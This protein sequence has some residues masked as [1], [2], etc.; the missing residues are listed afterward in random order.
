MQAYKDMGIEIMSCAAITDVKNLSSI[1]GQKKLSLT[2]MNKDT[3]ETFV[4]EDYEE[5]IWAVGRHANTG[6]LNIVATD[7]KLNDQGFVIT[8][9]FQNTGV[10]GLYSLGDIGGIE[11]LTPVAI[12]A[13]RKL[14][15][16]LFNNKPDSKLDYSL[17]PSVIFSHPTAGSIGLTEEA[18]IKKFGKENI[19]VY[20][21]KVFQ[22]IYN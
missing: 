16:R 12:A 18:A 6:P 7:V 13:G 9:E 19:K 15:E 22:I 5:L 17:I 10:P 3:L 8:D 1:Q 2:V 21:S 4:K 11:M 20:Q 14:S